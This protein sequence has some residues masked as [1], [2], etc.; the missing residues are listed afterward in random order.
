M[1]NI[2]NINP[3]LASTLATQAGEAQESKTNA[4]QEVSIGPMQT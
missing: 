2:Q 1:N 4:S 3:N